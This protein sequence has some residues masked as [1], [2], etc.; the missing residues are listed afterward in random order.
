MPKNSIV[1]LAVVVL[2]LTALI[3][4]IVIN[5]GLRLS[6]DKREQEFEKKVETKQEKIRQDLEEKYQADMVSYKAMAK[7]LALE[8]EKSVKMQDNIKSLKKEVYD[9]KKVLQELDKKKRK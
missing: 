2:L 4:F 5:L 6:L 7:R 8:K 9:Q 3:S 1:I